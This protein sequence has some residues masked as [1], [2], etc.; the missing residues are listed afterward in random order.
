[1]DAHLVIFCF[2]FFQIEFDSQHWSCFFLFLYQ[3]NYPR[4][5]FWQIRAS[6]H[7]G[8]QNWKNNFSAF[9]WNLL[10]QGITALPVHI[11]YPGL[12]IDSSSIYHFH[13]SLPLSSSSAPSKHYTIYPQPIFYLGLAFSATLSLICIWV[14]FSLWTIPSKPIFTSFPFLVTI[15]FSSYASS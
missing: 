10:T 11:S 14:F 5:P 1:M 15:F 3:Q 8:L 13:C 2:W 9:R 4:T 6:S 12:Y 7:R